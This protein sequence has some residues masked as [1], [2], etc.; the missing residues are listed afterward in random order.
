MSDPLPP[1]DLPRF[2]EAFR[3]L[4]D[5]AHEERLITGDWQSWVSWPRVRGDFVLQLARAGRV[6]VIARTLPVVLDGMTAATYYGDA[7]FPVIYWHPDKKTG[8]LVPVDNDARITDWCVRR[9][10][11]RQLF[12]TPRYA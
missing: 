11:T 1:K 9:G 12:D 3:L 7:S 4:I 10:V 5:G 6:S 8:V 2:A